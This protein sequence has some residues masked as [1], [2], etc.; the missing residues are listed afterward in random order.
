MFDI[1]KSAQTNEEKKRCESESIVKVNVQI[2][3]DT[4]LT[5]WFMTND[6]SDADVL[7]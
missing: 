3:K 7:T 5:Q 1:A 6:I 4:E 2:V